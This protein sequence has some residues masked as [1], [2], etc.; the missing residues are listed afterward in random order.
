LELETS[1]LRFGLTDGQCALSAAAHTARCTRG[2]IKSG[3]TRLL[4]WYSL[5]IAD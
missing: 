2:L 4:N 1:P 3:K 5:Y